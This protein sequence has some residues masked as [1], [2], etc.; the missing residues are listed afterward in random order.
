L[1]DSPVQEKIKPMGRGGSG[2]AA[3]NPAS[4]GKIMSFLYPSRGLKALNPLYFL[5][6]MLL[7]KE[8]CLDSRDILVKELKTV[9]SGPRQAFPLIFLN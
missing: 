7:I 2:S 9:V 8:V 3:Q 5:Y 1:A 6:K 4:K